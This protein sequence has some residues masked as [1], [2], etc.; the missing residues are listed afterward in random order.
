LSSSRRIQEHP[1]GTTDV[2][3]SALVVAE[4]EAASKLWLRQRVAQRPRRTIR[5]DDSLLMQHRVPHPKS[6]MSRR[7]LLPIFERSR[8]AKSNQRRPSWI[9]ERAARIVFS[10]WTRL[11]QLFFARLAGRLVTRVARASTNQRGPASGTQEARL[12]LHRRASRTAGRRR[13]A[14]RATQASRRA[15]HRRGRCRHRRCRICPHATRPTQRRSRAGR[16]GGT[17]RDCRD[18]LRCR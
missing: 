14:D 6:V 15:G 2:L 16:C 5:H 17:V 3:G 7:L 9:S 13:D 1:I 18:R 12:P 8:G 4:G 11:R 10:C